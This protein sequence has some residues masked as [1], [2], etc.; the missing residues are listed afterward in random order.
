MVSLCV[1]VLCVPPQVRHKSTQRQVNILV[2]KQEH[3]WWNRLTLQERKPLF[4]VPDFDRW[5]DESDAEME[6]QAK[7]KPYLVVPVI[8]G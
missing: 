5:L 4:L 8:S 7:V 2:K 1:C 3:C 6:L